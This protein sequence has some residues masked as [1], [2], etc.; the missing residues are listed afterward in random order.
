[1]VAAANTAIDAR[2]TPAARKA[3][4]YWLAG[5]IGAESRENFQ[6]VGAGAY[7]ETFH[8]DSES[9]RRATVTARCLEWQHQMFW[10]GTTQVAHDI[11]NE[12]NVGVVLVQSSTGSWLVDDY[13]LAPVPGQAP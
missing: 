10:H 7:L 5:A 9:D 8:V 4:D 3:F 6:V 12:C 13:E 11:Q 2:Q 1:M